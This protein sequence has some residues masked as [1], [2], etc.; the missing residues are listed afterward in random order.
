MRGI[1][2]SIVALALAAG[3][4]ARAA[5]ASA[6]NPA[7]TDIASPAGQDWLAQNGWRYADAA[8]A[9][10][11]WT[12]MVTTMSPW[13]D[14]ARP[15]VLV[16]SVGTRLQMAMAPGQADTQPGGFLTFD[17]IATVRQVR[18]LLAVRGDWKPAVD[19]VVTYEITRDVTV[20]I[21]P[22]GPQVDP[23]SCRLLPGGWTQVELLV[24][25]ADRMSVMKVVESHPI[26]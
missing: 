13:P 7:V 22:I 14:W 15:Q 19:H 11:A 12:A 1:C 4:P 20:A 18:D 26:H 9:K 6:C 23:T 25:P 21:G 10:V 16:L 17:G 3:A 5:D 8:A 2:L 24:A